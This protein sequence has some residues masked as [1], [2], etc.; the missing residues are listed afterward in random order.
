MYDS[1]MKKSFY[2]KGKV[3]ACGPGWHAPDWCWKTD[4]SVTQHAF[5]LL[6][7][8]EGLC[9]VEAA[10]GKVLQAVQ[11]DMLLMRWD[12]PRVERNAGSRTLMAPWC[13]FD[14]EDTEH[15]QHHLKHAAPLQ[16][17]RLLDLP[18]VLTCMQRVLDAHIVG[19]REEA[20]LYLSVILAEFTKGS[21][22]MKFGTDE[23][24]RKIQLVC[25][26][27]QQQPEVAWSLA[28]LAREH[29]CTPDHF[30]RMFRRSTGE[31]PG[32]YV[33]LCRMERARFLLRHTGDKISVIA[34]ELGYCDPYAFSKQFKAFVGLSPKSYRES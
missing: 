9:E 15:Q 18:F 26:R 28:D 22:P 17:R 33:I 11:G 5:S 24:P 13:S 23:W 2:P 14:W 12:A 20:G 10:D 30:T 25:Q 8:G 16:R 6:V 7:I 4:G 27:I 1:D 32:R 31:T 19:K 34:E 29:A 3:S 21:H